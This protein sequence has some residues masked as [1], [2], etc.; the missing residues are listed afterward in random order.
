MNTADFKEKETNNATAAETL[1]QTSYQ[2]QLT[3]RPYIQTRLHRKSILGVARIL[4][5]GALFSLQKLT[6]FFSRR[7][8]KTV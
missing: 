5:G 7:L 1:R 6:T 3:Y 2:Q 8:Q 4:F